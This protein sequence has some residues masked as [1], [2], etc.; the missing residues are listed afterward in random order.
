[1][2][3]KIYKLICLLLTS[4][5]VAWGQQQDS[6]DYHDLTLEELMNI[7][8]VSASKKSESLF[9][10]SL[11]ASVITREE[12]RNAGATSI[13]EALRLVPGVIVREQTNGNYDIHVR[14]LDNVPPNSLTL[15]S[16][17]TT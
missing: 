12:I 5:G 17:N 13:M 3:I 2:K 15:S 14:G 7:E 11:S 10:A 6:V 8:I 1:M 9:D 4:T 16:T